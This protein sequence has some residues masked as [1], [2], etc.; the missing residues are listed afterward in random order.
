MSR[1]FWRALSALTAIVLAGSRLAAGPA[2]ANAS[3]AP[4][5]NDKPV[6]D[7][8]EFDYESGLLWKVGGGATPLS[9]RMLPQLLTMKLPADAHWKVGAGT[10]VLRP[11]YSL[12]AEPIVYGP[13]RYF[14]GITASGS[15]EYWDASQHFCLFFS[16][17][18][19]AG[20]MHSKGK[21][22]KG[23]QGEDFNLTWL[24]YSGLR[25]RFS[26]TMNAGASVYFQHI[27][28]GGLDKV[29]PGVN[30]IGPMLSLGWQF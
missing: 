21:I 23:G 3:V 2:D 15:L 6:F 16:S 11:R 12:V 22:I 26:D 7:H 28:N 25:Y 29:N 30:A 27:S 24:I 9:Y 13:E 18:G 17:G 19:G 5:G 1:R 10:L 14:F 4:G 8:Y 20:V